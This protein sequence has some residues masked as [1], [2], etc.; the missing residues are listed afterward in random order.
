MTD[1]ILDWSLDG[2]VA[3]VSGAA[4]GVVGEAYALVLAALGATVFC[5]DVRID[6]GE[7]AAA[8]IRV[9]A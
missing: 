3:V 9:I 6:A 2:K 7:T 5:V 4:K 8:H 1:K